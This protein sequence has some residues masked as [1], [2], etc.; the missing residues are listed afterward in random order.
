MDVDYKDID[1]VDSSRQ[2]ELISKYSGLEEED[3]DS[4][5]ITIYNTCKNIR[6]YYD[7]KN[8]I[9]ITNSI[10]ELPGLIKNENLTYIPGLIDFDIPNI[11]FE[12]LSFDNPGVRTASIACLNEIML[13]NESESLFESDLFCNNFLSTFLKE[14]IDDSLEIMLKLLDNIFVFNNKGINSFFIEKNILAKI[15]N[16]IEKTRNQTIFKISFDLISIIC[17]SELKK[18][19]VNSIFKIISQLQSQYELLNLYFMKIFYYLLKSEQFLYDEFINYKYYNFVIAS[20]QSNECFTMIYGCEVIKILVEKY[21]CQKYFDP[22]QLLRLLVTEPK[23]NQKEENM[24]FISIISSLCS[25]IGKDEKLTSFLLTEESFK[26]LLDLSQKR[27]VSFIVNLLMIFNKL[28]EEIQSDNFDL[29]FIVQDDCTLFLYL[30]RLI[31]TFD[32]DTVKSVVKFVILIFQKSVTFNKT[33]PCIESFQNAFSP[34]I[35]DLLDD[36]EDEEISALIPQ[37]KSF[38]SVD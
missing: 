14:K 22:F 24:L 30:S 31:D 26:N 33:E 5:T 29:T 9:K 1:I 4:L 20:L 8:L 7:E 37:L 27:N 32:I 38:L 12:V 18:E 3:M 23:K 35:F 11:L 19:D 13:Y 25:F 2:N 36:L 10:L 17:K 21:D 28:Y 34:E 16:I 15:I 6:K